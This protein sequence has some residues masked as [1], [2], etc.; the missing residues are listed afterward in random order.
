[1]KLDIVDSANKKVGDVDL[2][3]TVFEV[4]VK[5][6]LLR[7]V[8]INQLANRRRGTHKAKGRAEVS[9]GG[10]KP[11]KQKGTGRARAGSIR[12]PLFRGGGIT[13]GPTPRD[14]SYKT[15]KKV[16]RAAL[17]SA[18]SVK[19]ADNAL[20]IVDGFGI[21]EPKTKQA[22]LVLNALGVTDMKTL[23]VINEANVVIEKSFH[24]IPR[25]KVI[26][27]EGVNVYD[28]LDAQRVV[29]VADAIEPLTAR[30]EAK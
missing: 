18:L 20:I 1:M 17:R 30:G 5:P 23:V 12:S 2:S 14:Y 3:A 22:A 29:V 26:R 7:D 25:V 16:R 27:V 15:P 21:T 28:L 6:H 10:V 13:F 8:V 19:A 9:G 24:N 4:E 11:W